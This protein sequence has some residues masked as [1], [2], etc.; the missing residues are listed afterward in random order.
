[1]WR[2]AGKDQ[3]FNI[4]ATRLQEKEGEGPEIAFFMTLLVAWD[5]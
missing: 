1:M 2:W 4:L 3:T 5:A